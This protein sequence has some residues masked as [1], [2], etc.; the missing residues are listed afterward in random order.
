MIIYWFIQFQVSE[1]CEDQSPRNLYCPEMDYR[2][3]KIFFYGFL[4]E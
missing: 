4:I 3:K 2:R 1:N